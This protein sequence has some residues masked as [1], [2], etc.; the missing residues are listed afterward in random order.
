MVVAEEMNMNMD[1][2]Y[3]RA[4]R[5][6]AERDG[7]RQRQLGRHLEPLDP[8]SAR[9]MR[10]RSTTLLDLASAKLGVPVAS[11]TVSDGVVS[12]EAKTRQLRRPARRQAVQR[13]A[14]RREQR[15][16][17]YSFGERA[18]L[19]NTKPVS[20]YTVVGKSFP[21]IDIPAKVAAPTRTSRTSTFPGML[22]ARRVRPRG[23]VRTRSENDTPL[24]VDATS[25]SHIPGAQVVQI[26][27]F[28]A[29]V[30]PKE[31]DAI[32]A[33]AQ[34]KVT[35]RTSKRVP[36]GLRQLLVVA[37]PGR[38]HRTRQNPARYTTEQSATSTTTL[39][40]AAKTV[41]APRT[42]TTTTLHADRPALR[43]RRRQMA[44][45]RRR[46]TS[47]RRR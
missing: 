41:S 2:M 18:G 42:S 35:W 17:D 28:I 30:A 11:L 24:N 23:A 32:Q 15:R 10:W 19:G 27:N 22:H 43:G 4:A 3:L 40:G 21:R 20:Q 12:A 39:A 9:R 7:R 6:V 16:R 26:N 14:D 25:I 45:R 47:R 8:A 33:A 34:L 46:S 13:P 37:P 1:Q 38:R 36:A 31:Y 5:D 44:E 29:V